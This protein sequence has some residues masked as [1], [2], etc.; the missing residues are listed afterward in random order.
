MAPRTIDLQAMGWKA[1]SRVLP[2]SR[3]RVRGEEFRTS[4][5]RRNAR[6]RWRHRR[7]CST[8][9]SGAMLGWEKTWSPEGAR[10]RPASGER[11]VK[12]RCSPPLSAVRHIS[13]GTHPADQHRSGP[14]MR[15]FRP[16]FRFGGAIQTRATTK[17]SRILEACLSGRVRPFRAAQPEVSGARRCPVRGQARLTPAS[18]ARVQTISATDR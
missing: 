15:S 3:E 11:R 14:S 18:A 2:W 8:V 6:T 9:S 17:A 12:I 7:F 16:A 5:A 1:P 13:H 4:R 10:T